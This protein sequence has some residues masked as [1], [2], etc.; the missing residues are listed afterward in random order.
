[1]LIGVGVCT[2]NMTDEASSANDGWH[3][4][5]YRDGVIQIAAGRNPADDRRLSG[6]FRHLEAARPQRRVCVHH[7]HRRHH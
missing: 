5:I 7:H 2:C 1:M 4:S 3:L 6:Y